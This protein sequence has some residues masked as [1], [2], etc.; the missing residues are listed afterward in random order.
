VNP[1]RAGLAR[2]YERAV[3]LADLPEGPVEFRLQAVPK[4]PAPAGSLA[5]I[6]AWN[7]GTE[8]PTEAANAEANRRLEEAL[9][10]SGR[11]YYAALGRSE[12]GTHVEPSFAIVDIDPPSALG[13][14][15]EFRQAA[16]FYWDGSAARLL[17]CE[18]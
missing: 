11:P 3:Y 12:D 5:I 17:W 1:T 4:G 14:A 16:V 6:T 10:S 7:P 2:A 13:L 18:G 9:K 8:R 15:R